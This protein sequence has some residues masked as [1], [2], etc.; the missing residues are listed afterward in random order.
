MQIIT[1]AGIQSIDYT[2]PLEK[3]MEI[4]VFHDVTNEHQTPDEPALVVK[5]EGF[6]IGYL[7]RLTTLY[8]WMMDAK[9]IGNHQKYEYNRDRYMVTESVR[10]QIQL[11]LFRNQMLVKGKI[12]RVEQTDDGDIKS[13]SCSF[14]YL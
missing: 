10:D 11:D 13:I 9:K 5:L 3:D 2:F 4:E 7:P 14:D 6:V 1:L 8:T 12:Y